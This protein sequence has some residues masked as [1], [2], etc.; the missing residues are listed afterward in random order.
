MVFM[1]ACPRGHMRAFGY[2]Y[3]WAVNDRLTRWQDGKVGEGGGVEGQGR[4]ALAQ[5]TAL[6]PVDRL[7]ENQK[8]DRHPCKGPAMDRRKS[9]ARRETSTAF[10][11]ASTRSSFKPSP[12]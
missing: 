2:A 4:E 6:A 5:P 9:A 3:A 1:W 11:I 12:S 7:G 10:G 8:I